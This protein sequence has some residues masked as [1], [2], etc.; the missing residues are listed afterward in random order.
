[1]QSLLEILQQGFVKH[2]L[3][4]TFGCVVLTAS[5]NMQYL[6]EIQHQQHLGLHCLTKTL[7]QRY[8]ERKKGRL[9]EM[10]V[11]HNIMTSRLRV[12]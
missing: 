3:A 9:D 2:A 11:Y 1:M 4:E 12:K 6:H 8:P 5:R 7:L 10:T